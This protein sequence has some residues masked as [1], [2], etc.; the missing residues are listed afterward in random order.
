MHRYK[1]AIQAITDPVSFVDRQYT[2][3]FVNKSYSRLY[4]KLSKYIVGRPVWEVMGRDAFEKVVRQRLDRC[5]KGATVRFDGWFTFPDGSRGYR[6]E[7]YYPVLDESG[8]EVLE[9]CILLRDLTNLKEAEEALSISENRFRTVFEKSPFLIAISDMQ[10][11]RL[12]EVNE[13]FC[14]EL[15]MQRDGFI[16]KTTTE[17][18]FYSDEDRALFLNTLLE[19]GSVQGLEMNFQFKAVRYVAKM[20]ASIISLDGKDYA[21]TQFE[22]VTA[23]KKVEKALKYKEDKYRSLVEKSNDIIWEYDPSSGSYSFAAGALT[24]ILGYLP[25]EAKGMTLDDL[26]GPETKKMVIRT[27]RQLLESEEQGDVRLEAKHRHKDGHFV[28]LEIL[29]SSV[30]VDEEKHLYLQGISRDITDRKR[31]E[32]ELRQKE[33]LNREL[34][35][36]TEDLVTVVDPK[37]NFT[38]VNHKAIDVFGLP[39]KECIGR[40]AFDFIHEEDLQSTKDWFAEIISLQRVHGIFENRQIN[41]RGEIRTISWVANL[42]YNNQGRIVSISAIGHD[43]T[44]RTRVERKLRDRQQRYRGLFDGMMESLALH[45]LV[46]EK[47]RPVDYKIVDCNSAF[48]RLTGIQRE[49]AVGALASELFGT[50]KHHTWTHTFGLPIQG[51]PYPSKPILPPCASTSASPCFLHTGALS[52]LLQ[53][54]LQAPKRR[55]T[56]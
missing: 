3:C 43:V 47:G 11:G 34:I 2:Y 23:Q 25:E 53:W 10:T 51:S 32:E 41:L 27:F 6:E 17:L 15:G 49:Q 4:G 42:H 55:M 18:G 48:V 5:F 26:F 52:P 40:R 9:A 46:Y 29:A 37:G 12:V 33:R 35:E 50:G 56:N 1:S 44:D 14:R 30:R 31:A 24:K 22:D 54:T 36:G 20:Y 45:E 21:L 8:A 16:G 7:S 38:Y 39:A 28:W 19:V 13:A